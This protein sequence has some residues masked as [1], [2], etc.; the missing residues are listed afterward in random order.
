MHIIYQ[1]ESQLSITSIAVGICKIYDL[2]NKAIQFD[3]YCSPSNFV[4]GA[5][6]IKALNDRQDEY[7]IKIIVDKH[8]ESD[9][10]FITDGEFLIY[11]RPI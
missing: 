1:G 6:C 7:K 5:E 8:L 10:Y 11:Y 4:I 3:L 9:D 2:G